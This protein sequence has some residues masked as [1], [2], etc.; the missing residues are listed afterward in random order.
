MSIDA[1][2]LADLSF[3]LSRDYDVVRAFSDAK[4]HAGSIDAIAGF[5]DLIRWRLE[6]NSAPLPSGL[7][8]TTTEEYSLLR[9]GGGNAMMVVQGG[10]LFF[11][12]AMMRQLSEASWEE[13]VDIGK[14][15][16]YHLQIG[17]IDRKKL[18]PV[19]SY[20]SF[21]HRRDLPKRYGVHIDS[22]LLDV[23]N[24]WHSIESFYNH[25]IFIARCGGKEL[26][27]AYLDMLRDCGHDKFHLEFNFEQSERHIGY[28]I[29]SDGRS[30]STPF[31]GD[32]GGLP[33]CYIIAWTR[34]FKEHDGGYRDSNR[35]VK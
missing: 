33:A 9:P 15:V 1:F 2:N 28:V 30:H 21:V 10:A 5:P 7:S 24:G 8:I 35:H 23:A 20:D 26:A 31:L 17:R 22:S 29:Q 16:G 18:F 6:S 25:P 12:E 13:G 32:L 34:K 11:D 19:Y 27:H 14:E 4:E 3:E